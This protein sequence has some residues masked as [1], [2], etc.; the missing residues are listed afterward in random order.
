MNFNSQLVYAPDFIEKIVPIEYDKNS[1]QIPMAKCLFYTVKQ[2]EYS[3]ILI[4]AFFL[5]T[6]YTFN[7]YTINLPCELSE[8]LLP[9]VRIWII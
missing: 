3:W 4:V 7:F 5:Y 8:G 2:S 6:L 9:Y 1:S